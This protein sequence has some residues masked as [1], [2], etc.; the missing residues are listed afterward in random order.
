MKSSSSAAPSLPVPLV[1]ALVLTGLEGVVMLGLA[2]V[3]LFS[4]DLGRLAMG[5]TTTAF[6]VGYGV[7]LL[8]CAYGVW[9]R[10]TWGRS[11]VVLAQLIQLGVAWSWFGG[12]PGLSVALAVVA[13]LVLVG[14]FVP[15][16][17]RALEEEHQ[18]V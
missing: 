11:P 12:T 4:L 8:W 16:S 3:E 18:Q 14:I 1:M 10:E 2:A 9:Q 13:V 17:L 5:L 6:F 7:G 15:S